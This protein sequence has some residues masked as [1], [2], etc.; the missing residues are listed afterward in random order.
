[1]TEL[2]RERR[3]G[4]I[5]VV[6]QEV[7]NVDKELVPIVRHALFT[8][9]KDNELTRKYKRKILYKW[10]NSI[11]QKEHGSIED[12]EML[13]YLPTEFL[14]ISSFNKLMLY[15][16]LLIH[17]IDVRFDYK[18]DKFYTDIED[19]DIVENENNIQVV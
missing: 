4:Y 7:S 14:I 18:N 17:N 13:L 10:I 2:T 9:Y 3:N 6:L 1:M 5:R 12:T 19:W 16:V 8:L 15:I 11:Y